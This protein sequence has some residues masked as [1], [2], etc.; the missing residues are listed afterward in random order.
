MLFYKEIQSQSSFVILLV[1]FV[2]HMHM[3]YQGLIIRL[4]KVVS[5]LVKV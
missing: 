1:E 3:G 4:P 5:V 2:A